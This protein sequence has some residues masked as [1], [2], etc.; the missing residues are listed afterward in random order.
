MLNHSQLDQ[1]TSY[2]LELKPVDM[3]DLLRQLIAT[4][5]P[6]AQQKRQ[7]LVLHAIN[8][9]ASL[10]IDETRLIVALSNLVDNALR[11]TGNDGTV[12]VSC[13]SQ[14]E[15]LTIEVMD[16]GPG[17][18]LSSLPYIFDEF[19][20]VE[21][22]RPQ[23]AGSGLGLSISKKIVELHGGTIE[24]QNR[25]AGGMSFRV[26]LPERGLESVQQ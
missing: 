5:E 26:H 16:E 13:Q 15:M 2:D 3:N 9:P 19:Y 22:H 12:V 17:I 21:E 10:H 14:R 18:P 24:A 11:Y 8:R 1:L 7:Q 25:P 4:F 6:M 23:T 20:R